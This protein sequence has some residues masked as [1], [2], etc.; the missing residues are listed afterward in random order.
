MSWAARFRLGIHRF[1]RLVVGVQP[2]RG[3]NIDPKS[4][5][6]RSRPGA[7]APLSR[8]LS[9]A[10]R[11]VRTPRRRSISA[12]TA[13]SNGCPARAP[14]CRPR[15][16][17]RRSSGACRTSIRSSST[18]PARASRPSAAPPAV[19]VDHLTPPLTRAELHGELSPAREPDRRI[20]AR[21]RP[22]SEAR[23]GG[24]ARRDRRWRRRSGSTST[25]RS[26]RD[27]PVTD[28]LR[29]LDA[30]L[31]DLKEMQI[32]DGLHVFG[33]AP[34]AAQLD[35][36]AGRDRAR[37]ALGGAARGSIAAARARRR[38]RARGFDPLTRDFAQPMTD[39]GR[40]VLRRAR[41]EAVAHAPATRSSGSSAWPGDLVS[42][43]AR[44]RP[45]LDAHRPRCSTGSTASLRPTI[46]ACDG[47]EMRALLAGLAGR[48]VRPGRR[49]RRRA[50][51]PTCCRPGEF[52]LRRPARRAD[53]R[54]PGASAGRGRAAGRALLAGGGRM[55]ARRSRCPPGA[56]P[57][58]A[59]AATTS[60]R[61]WR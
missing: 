10:A 4:K 31:C 61:R 5:L 44:M 15:A 47:A 19:I 1:G 35:R 14:A 7:A 60:R 29:A 3:Y 28:A 48:F 38:S 41:R 53:R 46:A 6:S 12:S 9:L 23:R 16:C 32:R 34:P 21:R 56:P 40:Q 22:R 39:R 59:P 58:C 43:R 57:T 13:I 20:C 54:P 8:V 45:G 49:A 18:I 52:L 50:A 11:R 51:G 55:A 36:P 27:A 42:G 25:S 2:A 24:V 33:R 37:A 26:R 30:H 17:P